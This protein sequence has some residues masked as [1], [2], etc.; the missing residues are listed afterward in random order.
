[1][2]ILEWMGD[3][4]FNENYEAEFYTPILEGFLECVYVSTFN[5]H[6]SLNVQEVYL[7]N[8]LYAKDE[9]KTQTLIFPRYQGV[10]AEGTLFS[11]SVEKYPLKSALKIRVT[12]QKGDSVRVVVRWSLG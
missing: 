9:T 10:D 1:M 4:V 7:Q 8:L 3:S 11:T 12:G 6:T 5:P 2:A